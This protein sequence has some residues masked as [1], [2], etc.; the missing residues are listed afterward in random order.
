MSRL[1]SWVSMNGYAYYIW[2][3]Y[4][5]VFFVLIANVLL[6]RRQRLRMRKLLSTWF[7]GASK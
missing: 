4:G 2:S 1:V 6:I 3:A 7:Y 5:A